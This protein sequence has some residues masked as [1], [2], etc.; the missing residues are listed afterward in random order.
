VGVAVGSGSPLPQKVTW[1]SPCWLWLI[2]EPDVPGNPVVQ[3]Y[4]SEPSFETTC[5]TVRVLAQSKSWPP[6][7]T[8]EI[9]I[10]WPVQLV[11]TSAVPSL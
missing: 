1:L 10:V 3:T 8:L 4:S 5:D 9:V 2:T 11:A 7:P 6:L